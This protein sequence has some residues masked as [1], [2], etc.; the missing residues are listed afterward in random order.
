MCEY[1]PLLSKEEKGHPLALGNKVT[2]GRRA[3]QIACGRCKRGS[4][5][6]SV[7]ACVTSANQSTVIL[8]P[9]AL[10]KQR[11]LEPLAWS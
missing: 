11:E 9:Q 2:K 5:A 6:V 10:E 3:L 7:T 1:L 4:A 8:L